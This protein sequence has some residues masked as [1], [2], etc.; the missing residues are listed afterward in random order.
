MKI[1]ALYR[2][3]V[4]SLGAQEL[5][6]VAVTPRGLAADRRWLVTN[7]QGRFVTRREL[8][9]MALIGAEHE[10]GVLILRDNQ[11]AALRVAEP[12]AD[13]APQTVT[14]WRD[15]VAAL[16]A[17]HDADGWLS[18]RLG[19]PL[20][21]FHMPDA[22]HR[23]VDPDYGAA[24]DEVSF[25]DGFPLLI[26]TT[27]SLAAL[28]ARLDDPMEMARFRPNIV[29]DG[30]DEAFAEDGWRSLQIGGLRLRVV[31][32]CTRC[33]VTT[34]HPLTGESLG[35]EPLRTLKAM[36]RVWERQPI[37][38]QNAIPDGAGRIAVGDA[39]AVL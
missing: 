17:G 25:A 26:T 28:N 23:A 39:V 4:K 8:S 18:E 37:F 14:V 20:R 6:E 29:L 7:P 27:A 22:S 33:V 10:D 36:G 15:P 30:V 1:A 3:P 32:P 38:G 9:G 24:G 2:Y 5:A 21:L 12:V 34:Q 16:P 35:N 19:R 13:T 11:G 31:K